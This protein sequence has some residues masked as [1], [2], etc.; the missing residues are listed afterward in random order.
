M[1]RRV[2]AVFGMLLL[3]L[4]WAATALAPVAGS[5]VTLDV[6]QP[7]ETPGRL[8][9]IEFF[10]W[11]C[12]HCYEFY[13][14]LGRWSAKLPASVDFRRVAVGFGNPQWTALARAFYAL[15]IT[16][17]LARLDSALF[18]AIHKEH[19][20]LVDAAALTAWVAQHGVDA[21]KFAAAYNSFSVSTQLQRSEQLVRGYQIDYVP[22]LAIAGRYTITGDHAQ[23]LTGAD[24][25]LAKVGAGAH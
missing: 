9:V 22:T 16:G 7:P 15:Q 4:P 2:Q 18:E 19:R 6:A 10:S 1:R 3:A 13:P 17:D 8:E 12:P 14:Q 24:A 25:L 20:P 21:G 23:M 11:G 5:Y